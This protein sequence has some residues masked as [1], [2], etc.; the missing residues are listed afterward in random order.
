MAEA[1]LNH[2]GKGRIAAKSA[3]SKP[4]GTVHPKSIALLSSKG[5]PTEGFHSKTWDSFGNETFDAV[6]TVCDQAAGES[7]PVFFGA[8]VKAHW[9]VPDPAHATGTDDEIMAAFEKSYELLESR[10]HALLSLPLETMDKQELAA[11]MKAIGQSAPA[12]GC[13]P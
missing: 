4:T 13:A 6:I 9:G 10:I 11:Q 5:I 12:G 3:G 2:F 7:C 8:P 1:A